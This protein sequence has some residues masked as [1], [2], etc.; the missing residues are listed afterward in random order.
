MKTETMLLAA[1][2]AV[3][4]YLYFKKKDD[5]SSAP[6]REPG[7]VYPGDTRKIYPG[8]MF[9]VRLSPGAWSPVAPAEDYI[10]EVAK[11]ETPTHTD[12]VYVVGDEAYSQLPVEI[13]FQRGTQ[14]ATVALVQGE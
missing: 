5:T 8:E 1:A 2:A 11:N 3:G 6:A 12:Y 14:V 7:I 9:T 4:G 10:H 13:G